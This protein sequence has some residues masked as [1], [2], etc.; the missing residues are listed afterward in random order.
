VK[1][2]RLRKNFGQT[3][4][5]DAGFQ[6]AQGEIFITL[7][8]DLQ[9]DPADIPRMI[10]KIEEG[11]D[12]VSGWRVRRR[13]SFGRR[14]LSRLANGLTYRVVGLYLHDYACAMKA[15]RKELFDGVH[16]YGEMHVFLPAFL[17]GRGARVAEIEVNHHERTRGTSK[18]NFMK[19]VKDLSDLV[20]TR[21]LSQ[22][23][24]RP[25]LFFSGWSVACGG[26]G[27][28]C[29]VAATVLKTMGLRNY[30]QTPLPILMVL[31]LLMGFMLF[32]MGFLAELMIRIY[33]EALNRPPYQVR[34]RVENA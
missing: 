22:Y 9:N 4:A 3:A 2:I 7:D 13:D 26:L 23:M 33:C 10:A 28:L 27:V 24:S 25:M 5:M 31:F 21:F 16:L 6:A 18:H 14:L 30:G 29:A 17:H 32:M 12:V 1:V 19:A 11:Y 20:T 8:G 34:D 15:Y